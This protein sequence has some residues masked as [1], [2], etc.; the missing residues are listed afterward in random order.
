MSNNWQPENNS[1]SEHGTPRSGNLL[2]E[3]RRQSQQLEPQQNPPPQ[4]YQEQYPPI[5]QNQYSPVAQGPSQQQGP[6][7]YSPLAQ[8]YNQQQGSERPIQQTPPIPQNQPVQQRWAANAM[9]KVRQWSGKMAVQTY[10]QPAPPMVLRHPAQTQVPQTPLPLRTKRWKR[11]RTIRVAMQMRHRRYRWQSKSPNGGRISIGILMAVM[12]LLFI[13][14]TSTSAY[15]YGYYQSQLPRVQG[16]ASQ[17][18]EQTTRMY[19]RNGVLLGD[20]FDPNGVG[21]RT[22]VQYKDIPKVMQ[23]AM[24]A[25][26]DKTFWTNSGVDPQGILRAGTAFLQHDSVQGGGSTLTQQLIK[27]MTGDTNQTLNRKLPEAALAIGLTQQYPK[28][29][30]MEMYF[31]VSP[32]GT[33]D[34]GVEAAAEEYFGLQRVCDP[35]DFKC[36]PGISKLEYDKNGKVNPVLGLARASLLAGMPQSP[37]SY[38]PTNGKTARSL[39][40]I[41]QNEVL[42]NMLAIGM[43][44][45][46]QPITEK[47]IQQ[48]ETLTAH[49]TFTRYS[50]TIKAPHFFEWVKQQLAVKLGHGDETAGLIALYSGGFN[51]RTTIDINL[52]SY[53]E[54][55]I[56][57][58]LNQ[59]EYQPFPTGHYA[60]LSQDNNVHNSAAVVMNAK[61]GEI[62]AMDG[63][64]DYNAVNDKTIDGQFNSATDAYR[65]P[66]STW[67]PLVYA[68]AFEMGMYPGT[69]LPDVKTY[70]PNNGTTDIKNAYVPPDY[71]DMYLGGNNTIQVATAN[72]RNVPAVKAL[73]FAGIEN[74][75]NTARRFGITALDED[76]AIK[77][78]T[79]GTHIKTVT[80]YNQLSFA[81]GSMGVPLIQ[82]TGAYQVFANQGSRIPPQSI[83]DIWDN[84]GHNLYHYD[85]TRPPAIRVISPQ[86]AYLMTSVLTDENSRAAEFGSD[87]VLSFND[88]DPTYTIHQVA[89]KTGTTDNFTDNWTMGYTPNVVVG[90]WSGNSDNTPLIN[91]V[92]VT[93]AA[94]IWHSIIERVSGKTCDPNDPN[95]D[96]VP[97]GSFNPSLYN[98]TQGTFTVPSGVHQAS[99]SS[100]DGLEGTGN[101]D[102]MLDGE[103]PTSYG[104]AYTAPTTTTNNGG[105]GHG[106]G[107]NGGKHG[108]KPKR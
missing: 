26:E 102:W 79:Q 84:Y 35:K 42:H 96:G 106:N 2:R 1:V 63:S 55:A 57:R 64:A 40:L 44:V 103:D 92:G 100:V 56:D 86:I 43:S 101:Y 30:I 27:N 22:P 19:D 47:M 104:I 74:V 29:K 24:I 38:D 82:M 94:P 71:G 3:Y 105:N 28:W 72:S 25:A 45:D 49:M 31:N 16:L 51:I 59:V 17:H 15:A 10:G 41:R 83:L 87:H 46:G 12:F 4:R 5:F 11:S 13:L 18:V 93:G 75:A 39:A 8:N 77:N 81:L 58:H 20:L 34:L 107:G 78:K 53:V 66:G 73:Q 52:E 68:T 99:T 67:K 60:T 36:T 65:S 80:D 21:R 76:I 97:C 32:F 48:A 14:T 61:T 33:L 95:F 88:W 69:V 23:D 9:Q 98:F 62:L 90:V 70:F 54:S 85:P 6:H 7:Q 108:G 37:V 50:Q 89:A 91:S